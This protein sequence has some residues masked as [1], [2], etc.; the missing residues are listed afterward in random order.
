MFKQLQSMFPIEDEVFNQSDSYTINNCQQF[1]R[2]TYK[3]PI[4]AE[5]K[6]LSSLPVEY[7]V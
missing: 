7:K 3:K 4:P 1:D 6:I 2:Y 5:S